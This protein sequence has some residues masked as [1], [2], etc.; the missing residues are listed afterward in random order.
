MLFSVGSSH[1]FAQ[2]HAELEF[3]ALTAVLFGY[4]GA[5]WSEPNNDLFL[6]TLW[7]FCLLFFLFVVSVPWY[8][9]CQIVILSACITCKHPSV[10]ASESSQLVWSWG[11]D[12]WRD[13]DWRIAKAGR[14]HLSL[15]K[16]GWTLCLALGTKW[17]P[18][19]YTYQKGTKP[20][21]PVCKEKAQMKAAFCSLVNDRLVL[22]NGARSLCAVS[23]S[24]MACVETWVYCIT[25]H[26]PSIS[27]TFEV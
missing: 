24:I 23:M 17:L 13:R 15:S 18:G 21:G 22:V 2:Q 3:I 27:S 6:I 19:W 25:A 14:C 26:S 12:R 5:W 4:G 20:H 8:A 10:F 7:L 16:E 11:E 1:F 9:S